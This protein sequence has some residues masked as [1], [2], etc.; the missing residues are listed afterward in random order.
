M[1][2]SNSS[3]FSS[4]LYEMDLPIITPSD[5]HRGDGTKAC[6]Q[7]GVVLGP[8]SS[9]LSPS[10]NV[11]S[12]PSVKMLSSPVNRRGKICTPRWSVMTTK[13]EDA[14]ENAL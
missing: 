13:I 14:Y 5:G 4:L 10:R 3:G 1:N 8:H 6:M 11:W 12:L 9:W 7:F 2:L